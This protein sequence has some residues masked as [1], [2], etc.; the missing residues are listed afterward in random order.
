LLFSSFFL[1]CNLVSFLETHKKGGRTGVVC[2]ECR[3]WLEQGLEQTEASQDFILIGNIVTSEHIKI[4]IKW[5]AER[6]C[7]GF[8]HP[9]HAPDSK[10][11]AR[12]SVNHPDRPPPSSP[13]SHLML[14]NQEEK[15]SGSKY[16]Q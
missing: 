1:L 4:R 5:Q 16:Y 9:C 2:V 3:K 14:N 13:Q 12:L 7:S 11:K 10:T 15:K 6:N 8:F